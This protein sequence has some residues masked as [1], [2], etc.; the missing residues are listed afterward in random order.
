VRM[1]KSQ[2]D[3]GNTTVRVL[4]GPEGLHAPCMLCQVWGGGQL[5]TPSW[6]GNS[7]LPSNDRLGQSPWW[8]V[9]KVGLARGGGEEVCVCVCVCKQHTLHS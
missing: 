8:G 4:P 2:G 5:S 9:R 7:L 6:E 3:L 1:M